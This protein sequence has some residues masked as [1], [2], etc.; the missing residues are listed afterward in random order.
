LNLSIQANALEG[1]SR[2][3]HGT[4]W[5]VQHGRA[6]HFYNERQFLTRTGCT[7]TRECFSLLGVA[8]FTCRT[9]RHNRL[10]PVSK[11]SPLNGTFSRL[12][13]EMFPG[14]TDRAASKPVTPGSIYGSSW[15]FNGKTSIAG[16]KIC[17]SDGG[18]LASPPA[19]RCGGL[20][21]ALRARL[22]VAWRGQQEVHLT[23]P[24]A[25]AISLLVLTRRRGED[26]VHPVGG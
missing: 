9:S 12:R 17:A 15:Q 6:E 24:V 20:A 21:G 5:P 1:D 11:S 18:T 3:L 13:D 23:R 2:Y 16:F 19:N 4:G 25:C 14:D 10:L 8:S 22:V 7:L 26:T